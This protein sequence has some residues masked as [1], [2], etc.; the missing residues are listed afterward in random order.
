VQTLE[1]VGDFW[2]VSFNH[3]VTEGR[4]FGVADLTIQ[5]LDYRFAG[6]RVSRTE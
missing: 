3:S 6:Q 5:Y 4:V 1:R 2:L